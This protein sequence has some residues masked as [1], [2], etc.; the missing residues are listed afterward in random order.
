MS[1]FGHKREYVYPSLA[2]NVLIVKNVDE[3]T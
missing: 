3:L 2:N 1:G